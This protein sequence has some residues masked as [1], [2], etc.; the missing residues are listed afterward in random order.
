M[1]L[2]LLILVVLV[3]LALALYAVQIIPGLVSPFR[4]LIMVVLVLIGILVLIQRS[5]VL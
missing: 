2:L 5:G 4:E 3:V 1:S